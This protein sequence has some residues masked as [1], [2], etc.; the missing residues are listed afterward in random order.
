MRKRPRDTVLQIVDTAFRTVII[1][2]M[3]VQLGI[4]HQSFQRDLELQSQLNSVQET[5]LEMTKDQS[6]VLSHVNQCLRELLEFLNDLDT[7]Q[8]IR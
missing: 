7:Q 4:N 6:E 1:A 3:V 8:G 2:C 5:L